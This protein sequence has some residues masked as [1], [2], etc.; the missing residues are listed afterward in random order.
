VV[1]NAVSM[2]IASVDS[3]LGST[4]KSGSAFGLNVLIFTAS[5]FLDAMSDLFSK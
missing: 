4:G 3:M 1:V 5:D 2:V